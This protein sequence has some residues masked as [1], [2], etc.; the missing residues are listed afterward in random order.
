M[1]GQSVPRV[2]D[3]RF[4]RGEGRYVADLALPFMREAYVVRSPHAHARIVAID[5]SA[6]RAMPEVDSVITADELPSG[7][8]P[9]P[10]RIPTHGDMTPFLQHVLARGVVRYVGEPIAVIVAASRALAEDAAERIAMEF[11]PLPAVA[12]AGAALDA[13]APKIHEA[14]NVASRWGF[15]LGAV[16]A[17]FAAADAVVAER[18]SVQRH[19][20]MPLETRGLLAT[21]DKARSLLEVFGPTK[22]PHTNRALLARMLGMRDADI[23]FVEPDVGG[24]F[25]A[26]GEFYPEDLLIPLLAMRIG[27]PVRW[28]EDRLEHFS[29]INHSRECSFEVRAA[30]MKDGR[31]T[32]FDV[33]LLADLGAYIR[34]HGDVVPS[35]ASASFPGP[36]AIRNYRVDATAALSNKTPTGTVRAPGMFEANFAREQVVDMLAA[37]LAIDP[38]EIR[39]R[40]FIQPEQMPWH[41]GTES[42]K[43]ATIFDSGDF[44]ALFEQ[45]LQRFGWAE[46]KPRGDG[47]IR[48]GRG[49]AALVEPSGLGPF[50][51]ARIEIDPDGNATIFTGASNQGQGHETV[52]PQVAAEVLGIPHGRFRV[53]HGDTA[54][55]PYGGGSYASRTA[56]MAGN[57]VH[58]AA[59]QVRAKALRV[60]A[61]LLQADEDALVLA[62]GRVAVAAAPDRFVTLGH[63]ARLLTPG[64][65]ELVPAPRDFVRDDHDGLTGTTFLRAI[66][67]GTSVFS[68]HL[69]EVAL[70]TETGTLKV[71]RYC[72][73]A[74]VGRAINPAV[75]EGQLV[76]GAVQ[77]IG[78][79]LLEELTYD[80]A[81]QLLTG[82]FADYLLPCAHDA[83]LIETL[84]V[85]SARATSNDLGVKG[86]GEVGPSGT[87]AAIANAVAVA[88]GNGAH[89]TALP[90]RPDRLLALVDRV[91]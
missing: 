39:R 63:I 66:P 45:A 19:T 9:I 55:I 21:Y 78:G 84:I 70:D 38:A 32:A 59:L 16:D 82:T 81:G 7:L 11:D 49:L 60:A 75:V 33:K 57:A 72:I 85:E 56:V 46:P 87:A 83:P 44:P 89:P 86:V 31:I 25:G 10:C 41:V 52:L 43:R 47:P 18:F 42:V 35:H 8:T 15:D 76:G 51:S 69:A 68:V 14:G 17:A 37:K 1:I 73:A 29:A 5:T 71:E 62:G 28:I 48:R 61:Q 54:L 22:V 64:N 91:A 77:G 2:E 67:S 88:L 27:R 65:P 80:A 53:R 20:A 4:L 74:D 12:D 3:Y 13:S 23:R 36:Y 26:R 90:L 6:A 34:T 50:E 30:A 24:S 40:N 79:A 58:R